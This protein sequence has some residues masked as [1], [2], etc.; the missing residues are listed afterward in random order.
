MEQRSCQYF[1]QWRSPVLPQQRTTGDEEERRAPGA[2]LA[3]CGKTRHGGNGYSLGPC[4]RVWSAWCSENVTSLGE[5]DSIAAGDYERSD[6]NA[7][8]GGD[9]MGRR[10][11]GSLDV[12]AQ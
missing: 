8:A 2:S 4:L 1:S 10:W 5:E 7:S 11:A 12:P 3:L 9:R 6:E